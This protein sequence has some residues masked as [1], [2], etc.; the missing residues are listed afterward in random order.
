MADT[1]SKVLA[2]NPTV[3]TCLAANLNA[4]M[5]RN[6]EA[7]AA[8]AALWGVEWAPLGNGCEINDTASST[9]VTVR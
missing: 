7:R 9:A 3:T 5:A 4:A 1:D 8:Y 6:P 2:A